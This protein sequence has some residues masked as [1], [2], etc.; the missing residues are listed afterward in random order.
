MPYQ[1]GSYAMSFVPD[2]APDAK[3]QWRELAVELQELVLDEMEKLAQNP[4][5]PPTS[6]VYH[7][8][9]HERDGTKHNIFL[10]L[11]VDHRRER[12]T[13]I[14]IVHIERRKNP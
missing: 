4:P 2:F 14:G 13:V 9:F 10:R 6:V 11:T 7:D 8:L 5:P 1:L 12:L 3:S